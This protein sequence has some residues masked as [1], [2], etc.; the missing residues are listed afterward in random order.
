MTNAGP[1]SPANARRHV[2]PEPIKAQNFA[3]PGSDSAQKIGL[4]VTQF[5]ADFSLAA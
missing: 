3:A 1:T 2:S 5:T 4:E